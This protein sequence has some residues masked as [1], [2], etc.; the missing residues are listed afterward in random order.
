MIRNLLIFF[1]L[2]LSNCHY[3][4]INHLENYE[5]S[6]YVEDL[7]FDLHLLPER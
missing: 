6:N 4:E 1:I 7:K 5:I 2:V 3:D